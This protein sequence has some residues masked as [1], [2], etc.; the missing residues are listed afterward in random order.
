MRFKIS[1]L[2][3]LILI[4]TSCEFFTFKK[5]S[6]LKDVDTIINFSTVDAA[7]TFLVCKDLIEVKAKNNCFRNTLHKELSKS[8]ANYKIEVRKPIN[9]EIFVDITI[10]SKGVPSVKKITLSQLIKDT[11]KNID[12]LVSE[13]VADLPKLFPA[14]KRGIPVTTQYQI[15]IRIHIK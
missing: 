11:I 13:S 9:E 3:L 5:T 12:S 7:P 2:F 14:T 15:P 8:F 1:F 6:H 10:D 4:C